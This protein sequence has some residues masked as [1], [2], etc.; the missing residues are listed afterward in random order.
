MMKTMEKFMEK[1]SLDNKPTTR[2]QS[3]FQLRNQNFKRAPGPQIR[4]RDQRYQGDQQIKPPF[5]NNYM[6]ENFDESLEDNIH[7][8]DDT[9]TN[10]FLSK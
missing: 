7:C 4:K 10:V 9:E 1:L 6:N 5:Q 2:D 3:N 8:C